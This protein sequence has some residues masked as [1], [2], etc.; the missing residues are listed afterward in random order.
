LS[1]FARQTGKLMDHYLDGSGAPFQLEPV[2]FTENRKVQAQLQRLREQSVR[3]GCNPGARFSSP[4]FYMPDG[5]KLDSV[6]GLYHGTV[7]AV[8]GRRPDG[9][10]RLQFRAEVPWV[11]PDYPSLTRKYGDPH[12]ESFPLPSLRSLVFG[13]SQSLFVDNGLGHYLEEVKL[14]QSFLAYAEWSE[15]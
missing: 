9:S 5:S 10:C 8:A 11:W 14:A 4:R 6:F 3:S 1:I 13:E 12:A 2:I 15:N 7:H